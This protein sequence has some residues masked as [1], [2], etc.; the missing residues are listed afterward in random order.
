MVD[1]D[2][3][4]FADAFLRD[5]AQGAEK[6]AQGLKQAVQE[7][8]KDTPL[9]HDDVTVLVRV[10]ANLKSLAKALR[11]SHVIG[12]DDDMIDFAEKFT[13]S[14]SEFDFVNVGWG[15]ENADSKIR[16]QCS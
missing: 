13:N 11:L 5:P 3:A 1:G 15:K 8:L 7:Q 12:R 4:K 16:S 10:Y 14:R 6:A 2:G 9:G